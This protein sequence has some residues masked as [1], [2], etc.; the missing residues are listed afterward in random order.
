MWERDIYLAGSPEGM[1]SKKNVNPLL[2]NLVGG[3]NPSE[4]NN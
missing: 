4:K 3:F 2:N 1:F